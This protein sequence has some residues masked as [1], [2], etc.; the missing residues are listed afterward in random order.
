VASAWEVASGIVCGVG[1]SPIWDHRLDE[2]VWIDITGRDL[3]RLSGAG[4][5]LTHRLDARPG[6]VALRGER[7]LVVALGTGFAVTASPDERPVE[8]LTGLTRPELRFNDGA[9]DAR[10]RMWVGTTA[11][12]EG[13]PPGELLRLDPS[14]NTESVLGSIGLSNGIGWAP[15]GEVMYHVD[16]SA[17][18]I[19]AFDFDE[20]NARV[21]NRR[22][23]AAVD[24]H[25]GHPDGIAVDREGG[26]WVA[27][28]GGGVIRR[29]APSGEIDGELRI[30]V[31]RV[32]S[33]A[34]GGTRLDQ[35][36]VTTAARGASLDEPLAGRLFRLEPGVA[37]LPV[38]PFA[39]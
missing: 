7:G 27:L 9:C 28:W 16:T 17:Q 14:G 2:I 13:G 24:E 33:C 31:R 4:A 6:A 38:T 30:P 11:V 36:Y 32:T 18:A 22:R 8:S 34:F 21:V 5:E 35:M 15:S 19:F 29:Y 12:L 3:H 26:V 10:G 20:R 37:G 23:F 39:G 1:E 25:D